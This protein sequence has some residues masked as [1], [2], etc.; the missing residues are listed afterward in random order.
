M[1][2]M[3]MTNDDGSADYYASDEND[4]HDDVM[5]LKDL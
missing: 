3:I 1:V 5:I 4:K 2:L